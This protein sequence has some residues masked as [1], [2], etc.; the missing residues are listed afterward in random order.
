MKKLFMIGMLSL[1]SSVSMSCDSLDT[2]LQK[3]EKTSKEFNRVLKTT[4]GVPDVWNIALAQVQLE[5]LQNDIQNDVDH[6]IK[7]HVNDENSTSVLSKL[8]EYR[9]DFKLEMRY[10]DKKFTRAKI[11]SGL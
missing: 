11:A 5:R 1:L 8:L 7:C 4:Y 10:L 3:G 2:L 6:L 9:E